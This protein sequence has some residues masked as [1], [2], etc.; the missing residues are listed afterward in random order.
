MSFWKEGGSVSSVW[1]GNG[2]VVPFVQGG[3]K[4]EKEKTLL[5]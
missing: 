4:K 3:E 1:N 5:S 2:D